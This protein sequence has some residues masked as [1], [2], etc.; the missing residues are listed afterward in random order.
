[1]LDKIEALRTEPKHIRNRYA[2][3]LALLVTLV[4]AFFWVMSIPT[5]LSQSD[6][7][8]QKHENEQGSFSRT[9]GEIKVRVME[10][11]SSMRTRVEYVQEEKAPVEENIHTLDL[12]AL[13]ASSSEMKTSVG[14]TTQ[15]DSVLEQSSSTS[16]TS[17]R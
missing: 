3:W 2:F 16:A 13:V 17:K 15:N 6:P 5:K 1:M 8:T 14:T 7:Q 11:V 12:R 9:L 4:I 10:I